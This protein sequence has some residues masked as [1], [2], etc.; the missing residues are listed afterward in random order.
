MV[1]LL[2]QKDSLIQDCENHGKF[3]YHPNT[4]SPY[5][6]LYITVEPQIPVAYSLIVLSDEKIPDKINS[7]IEAD[8]K[9]KE[10]ENI[11]SHIKMQLYI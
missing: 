11:L 3:V 2:H 4:H 10:C 6:F 8:I 9:S 1:E 7:S 5:K